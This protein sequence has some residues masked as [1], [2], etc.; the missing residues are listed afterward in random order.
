MLVIFVHLQSV[1]KLLTT[2]RHVFLK[3]YL[4]QGYSE[5]SIGCRIC[6]I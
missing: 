2:F 3:E 4:Q 5:K 6:H 1:V